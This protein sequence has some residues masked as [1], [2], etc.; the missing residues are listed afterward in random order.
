MWISGLWMFF[1]RY[2]GN[3]GAIPSAFHWKLVFVVLATIGII[4]MDYSSLRFRPGVV[5]VL[6]MASDLGL[7]IAVVLAVVAFN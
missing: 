3:F 5:P 1:D 7:V 6:G 2:G 4:V